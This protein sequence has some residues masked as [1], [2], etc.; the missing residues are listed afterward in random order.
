MPYGVTGINGITLV[1]AEQPVIQP[2]SVPYGTTCT[3]R[4]WISL[5]MD[6]PQP[7]TLML[8]IGVFRPNGIL[9]PSDSPYNTELNPGDGV[10]VAGIDSFTVDAVGA[11]RADFALASLNEARVVQWASRSLTVTENGGGNGGNGGNGGTFPW[12]PIVA[13][14]GIILVATVGKRKT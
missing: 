5:S 12:L 4:V 11:W 10:E 6:S 3:F 14:V 13:V 9:Y 7:D 8:D 2:Y 1:V